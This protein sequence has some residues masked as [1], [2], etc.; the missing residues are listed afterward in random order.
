MFLI[1]AYSNVLQEGYYK[2]IIEVVDT[3]CLSGIIN[4][5]KKYNHFIATNHLL[6]SNLDIHIGLFSIYPANFCANVPEK[7]WL[8]SLLILKIELYD[9]N[10]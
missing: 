3:K 4:C 2:E 10:S 6:K 9:L 5:P 7:N 1:K 8:L